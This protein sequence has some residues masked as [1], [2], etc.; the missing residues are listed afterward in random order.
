MKAIAVVLTL[1][2]AA[3]VSPYKQEIDQWRATRATRLKADDGWLSLVGLTW[4][5]DGANDVKRLHPGGVQNRKPRYRR[6]ASRL[7]WIE[8]AHIGSGR[9]LHSRLQDPLN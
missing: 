9:K 5:H 7:S 3:A 2:T 4:I 6:F 8:P 1:A